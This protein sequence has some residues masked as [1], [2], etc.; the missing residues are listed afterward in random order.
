MP[1]LLGVQT[2]EQHQRPKPANIF[3]FC[4]NYFRDQASGTETARKTA[5]RRVET[6]RETP[7][8]AFK[9]EATTGTATELFQ[10][11]HPGHWGR[12]SQALGASYA[13]HPL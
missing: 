11:T 1:L 8:A 2:E 5:K 12:T 4:P 3:E 9:K 7:Q 13:Q 10:K 6:S